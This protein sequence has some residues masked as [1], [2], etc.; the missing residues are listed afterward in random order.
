M[1][2]TSQDDER[3]IN[4]PSGPSAV[5][6]TQ[7]EH[8]QGLDLPAYETEACSGM[9]VRAAIPEDE[10]V[11]LLPGKRALIPTGLKVQLPEN[12]EIQIRPRSG[13]A[14]EHGVTVL[15]APGTIDEDYRGEIG[16]LLIN[17]GG[18]AFTVTR[19]QR[20]AQF[21]IATVDKVT[22]WEPVESLSETERGDGGFGHTGTE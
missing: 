20:I 14:Y 4:T 10:P 8:A 18:Q 22:S 3:A 11:Q 5:A 12:T 6:I 9:D 16:V 1:A 13:L 15:N 2:T 7:L 17:H 21:V 19:G